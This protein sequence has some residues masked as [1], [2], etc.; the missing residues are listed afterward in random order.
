MLTALLGHIG[1]YRCSRHP[2]PVSGRTRAC[3]APLDRRSFTCG[4]LGRIEPGGA[5][6]RRHWSVAVPPR[7]SMATG[8]S[9]TSV[10]CRSAI[11]LRRGRPRR[12]NTASWAGNLGCR[13][14]HAGR[15]RPPGAVPLMPGAQR[16]RAGR[17]LWPWRRRASRDSF[18]DEAWC[19][20]PQRPVGV[21]RGVWTGAGSAAAGW[22]A[23]GFGVRAAC[24]A[25]LL[26]VEAGVARR[27]RL[28]QVRYGRCGWGGWSACPGCSAS[29]TWS[30]SSGGGWWIAIGL[31]QA[32]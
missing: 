27:R 1:E 9:P 19:R 24:R 26:A 31:S 32:G 11:C 4:Q 12:G 14:R 23:V 5:M 2:L 17:S 29:W 7:S 28:R 6:E 8:F 13:L 18:G 21:S 3:A 20:A 25:F 16:P 15:R 30:G 10:E 22:A